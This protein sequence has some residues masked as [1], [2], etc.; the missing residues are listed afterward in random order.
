MEEPRLIRFQ[1]RELSTGML[2]P[3]H[4]ASLNVP[5]GRVSEI[6]VA[7]ADVMRASDRFAIV[8]VAVTF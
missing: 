1:S 7:L 6:A 2:P 4:P 5:V 8:R 3:P